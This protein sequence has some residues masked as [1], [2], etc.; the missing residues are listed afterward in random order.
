MHIHPYLDDL[1]IRSMNRRKALLDTKSTI[2]SLQ[3]N[4]PG[5]NREKCSKT[6]VTDPGWCSQSSFVAFWGRWFTWKGSLT[7]TDYSKWLLLQALKILTWSK[8]YLLSINSRAHQGLHQQQSGLAQQTDPA[9][10]RMVSEQGTFPT[11]SQLHQEPT[12]RS[13]CLTRKITSSVNSSWGL[14]ILRQKWQTRSW[15]H[16]PR[17][18]CLLFHLC[19]FCQGCFRRSEFKEWKSF[20]WLCTGHADHG[21]QHCRRGK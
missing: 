17:C 21:S 10:G 20:Q 6:T 4:T 19:Q 12:G 7:E 16:S 3:D 5:R 13:I 2:Q 18:C 15:H 1:L 8:K 11:N 9:E 14:T